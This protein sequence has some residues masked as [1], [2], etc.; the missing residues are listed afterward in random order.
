[1]YLARTVGKGNEWVDLWG[2][3]SDCFLFIYAGFDAGIKLEG[4]IRTCHEVQKAGPDITGIGPCL[5]WLPLIPNLINQYPEA[6][7]TVFR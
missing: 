1:M 7:D 2:E 6:W 4:Y 5:G 3:A